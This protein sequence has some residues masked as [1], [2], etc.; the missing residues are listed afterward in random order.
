MDNAYVKGKGGDTNHSNSN[1]NSNGN[2]NGNGN[3]GAVGGGGLGFAESIKRAKR[4]VV[5]QNLAM[6]LLRYSRFHAVCITTTMHWM[7]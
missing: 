4:D 3:G 6:F 7:Y 5:G 1:S 2:G